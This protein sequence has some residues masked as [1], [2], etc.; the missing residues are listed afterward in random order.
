METKMKKG[1]ELACRY[2][3]GCTMADGLNM[4]ETLLKGAMG[5]EES[6]KII[7]ETFKVFDFYPYLSAIALSKGKD[8]WDPE[9][10]KAYWLAKEVDESET[11]H[12]GG[13]LHD[14]RKIGEIQP[15][16]M[17][18]LLG[19]LVTPA[20]I[21]S[22]IDDDSFLVTH[23]RISHKGGVFFLEHE[24]VTVGQVIP[25][26]FKQDELVSLHIDKIRD[27]ITPEEE[28]FLIRANKEVFLIT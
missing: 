23:K 26:G 21:I 19:C 25:D 3:Y 4:N 16:I 27:R 14:L 13:V 28:A 1:L 8:I 6:L 24:E 9:M 22:V 18:F 17:R 11:S 2:S 15:P 20:R 5:D 7:L 10:V 12:A